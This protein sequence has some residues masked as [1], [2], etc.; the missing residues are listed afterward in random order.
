M[1]NINIIQDNEYISNAGY[2]KTEKQNFNYMF[3]AYKK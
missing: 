2:K 1:F 3:L